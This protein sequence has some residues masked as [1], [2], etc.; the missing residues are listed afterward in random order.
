MRRFSLWALLVVGMGAAVGLLFLLR[1]GTPAGAAHTGGSAPARSGNATGDR[2]E[3]MTRRAPRPRLL[4]TGAALDAGDA[5]DP[6]DAEQEARV[7][8]RDDGS[9]VRDHRA[10]AP[11]PG[12]RGTVPRPGI[13]AKV[14]PTAILAVRNAMR[15]IVH[16]CSESLSRSG[17]GANPRIQSQVVISIQNG[18]LVVDEAIVEAGDVSATDAAG[19]RECVESQVEAMTLPADGHEDVS[20]Y[21]LRLPYRLHQ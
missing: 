19:V 18:Q 16:Q 5:A 4:E 13:E 14:A 15:P 8:V 12:L 6:G 10:N 3:G 11:A 7:Y 21:T 9:L 20:R 17:L 1:S 2:Q